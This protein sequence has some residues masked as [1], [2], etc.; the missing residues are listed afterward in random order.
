MKKNVYS[1][2]LSEEIVDAID[3]LS[4]QRGTNRSAMINQILAEYVSYTTP[5]MHRAQIFG[6]L[7]AALGTE[8]IKH[9]KTSDSFFVLASS[10]NFKYNPTV[11]YSVE[12]H[13]SEDCLGV[14]KASLRTQNAALVALMADFC[15]LWHSLEE[16][17][18]GGVSDKIE[19]AKYSRAFV[20][21]R[22]SSLSNMLSAEDLGALIAEYIRAFDTAI[23]EYFRLIY[24]PAL[25]QRAV[26]AVYAQ[27]IHRTK[28]I[29]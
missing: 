3:R 21:R 15:L 26:E 24:T 7:E 25:A 12:L 13:L 6:S 18:L 22:D 10:I 5:S 4:Y 29:I 16:H 1:L 23:K 17:V 9:I 14:F 19:A 27:Y 28:Q 8:S 2:V 20:L 11:R